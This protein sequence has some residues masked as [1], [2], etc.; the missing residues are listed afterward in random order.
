MVD[1]DNT[2][3]RM[4]DFGFK[5]NPDLVYIRIPNAEE[6]IRRG[7]KYFI[8]DNAA[9]IDKYKEIVEWCEDNHGRGL[10]VMGNCGTGKTLICGKILPILINHYLRRVVYIADAKRLNKDIDI[11]LTQHQIYI[12]D[13]GIEDMSVNYGE[14]RLTFAEIVDEAEKKGKLL[15]ITTN[16]DTKEIEEKYG[17]RTID[18][19]RAITKSITLSG[20]SFRK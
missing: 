17:T 3:N 7:L 2:I 10:L 12:D 9:W 16:L 1:F 13:I 11:V 8:G 5:P 15:I 20:K 6:E 4:N 18:R 14:K 19:L